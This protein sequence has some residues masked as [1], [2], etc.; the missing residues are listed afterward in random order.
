MDVNMSDEIATKYP[1]TKRYVDGKFSGAAKDL[2]SALKARLE[3]REKNLDAEP[4]SL[5][6]I[7]SLPRLPRQNHVYVCPCGYYAG[8]TKM[9]LHLKK[10]EQRDPPRHATGY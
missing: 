9:K 8:Q 3:M 6:R 5:I 2:E 4:M 10:N 7:E 1:T